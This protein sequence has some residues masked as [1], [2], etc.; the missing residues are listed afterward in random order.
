MYINIKYDLKQDK[1]TIDTNIK[2]EMLEEMLSDVIRSQQ[3]LGVD[4]S[5]YTH[6]EIYNIDIKIDLSNDNISIKSDT[7]NDSL[8]CGIIIQAFKS[9]NKEE[10]D[11]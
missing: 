5:P 10:D 6:K 8:T 1:T 4:D 7:G 2:D 9:V 3:G 11:V